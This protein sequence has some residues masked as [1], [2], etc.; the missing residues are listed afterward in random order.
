MKAHRSSLQNVVM[1]SRGS[2]SGARHEPS[3]GRP[4]A[5]LMR[6][7]LVP[8]LALF[9]L[10]AVAAAPPGHS[11][12]SHVQASQ[13]RTGAGSVLRAHDVAAMPCKAGGGPWMYAKVV[14]SGQWMYWRPWMYG[15]PWMYAKVVNGGPWMY[16]VMNE[17]PAC[18]RPSQ[19]RRQGFQSSNAGPVS[20]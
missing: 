15:R 3:A 12:R 9:G 2:A 4:R 5:Q 7:I 10:T 6:A 20:A 14:N 19:L 17:R 1:R 18:T 13:L 11:I 16:A 8:S